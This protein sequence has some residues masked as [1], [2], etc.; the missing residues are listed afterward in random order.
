M[1]IKILKFLIISFATT[2]ILFFV[3]TGFMTDSLVKNLQVILFA[4]T[5]SFAIVWP[6]Y[7]K[8]ILLISLFLIIGMVFFFTLDMIYW[9]DVLGSTS[10]GL[11]V[12]VLLSYLPQF[13]K[14]GYIENL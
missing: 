7:R 10:I 13:V 3:H 1:K 11:V 4:G 2:P 9:A 8:Y 14:K 6:V 5:F 12:L